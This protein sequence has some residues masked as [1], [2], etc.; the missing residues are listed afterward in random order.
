MID[1]SRSGKNNSNWK[2]SGKISERAKHY[3]VE[4]KRGKASNYKC[5]VCGAPAVEWA[6][7]RTNGKLNG[8]YKPY[9]RKCHNKLDS[10]I[11]NIWK[12]DDRYKKVR[13]DLI[14]SATKG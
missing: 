11:S 5:V 1:K 2:G 13:K 8:K 14:K 9:C 12:H 4:A 3:R 10:K 7:Q 6:E